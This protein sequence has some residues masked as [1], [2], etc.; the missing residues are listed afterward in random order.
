VLAPSVAEMYP[1]W[2]EAPATTVRVRGL[3]DA[4]EGAARPGHFDGVVTVVAKLFAMAGRCRAY[5]GEKDFQQLEL[6]RGMVDAFFLDLEIVPV[7]TVR[8]RDGLAMSSRNVRLSPEERERAPAFA[9]ILRA[10]RDAAEARRALEAAGFGVD[11]VEDRGGR[12]F[13]AVKLGEV[14]LIDNMETAR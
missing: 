11:Y 6:I 4:W 13:G 10:S 8:E 7:P 1:S 2:P 5:F 12:R 9:R 3:T 14:R